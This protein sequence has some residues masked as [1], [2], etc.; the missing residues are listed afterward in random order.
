LLVTR[1]NRIATLIAVIACAF[2]VA[3]ERA[4]ANSLD[5][6]ACA[7]QLLEHWAPT[8]VQEVAPDDAGAD[9]PT[10]VDFDGDWD[11][12]NNWDNQARHGTALPPAAY[13]AAIL[14]ATHA[15]LTYTLYYPRD[16]RR[17]HCV[18]LLCHDNDLETVVVVVERDAGMGTLAE[19]RIK[20]HLAFS[21]TPAAEI[22]TTPEGRPLLAV[23]PEGHGIATCRT[24]DPRCTPVPGTLVYAYGRE[25]SPPPERAEGQTVQ[26][27][28]L[29]LRDTL[30]ARRSISNQQLWGEGALDYA[31]PRDGRLG[32]LMGTVMAGRRYAGCANPPWAHADASGVPGSWF[33]DPAGAR[34]RYVFNPFLDDL[35]A[36]CVGTR[37]R[38]RAAAWPGRA[39][40]SL[41]AA[42]VKDAPL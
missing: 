28:L 3:P 24:D 11:T 9:R 42:E 1:S 26:Y 6:A 37:C 23:E 27:E 41:G 12:T 25:A 18:P 33:L 17:E 34:Q 2:T 36:E 38:P 22:A 29:S 14:T 15:Y 32:G 7:E 39:A 21:T 40:A 30:W 20:A 4:K 35:R 31:N 10:R 19:V 5:E 16:W 13:G 8:Y